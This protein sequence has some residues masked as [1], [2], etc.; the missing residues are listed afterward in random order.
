MIKTFKLFFSVILV[1]SIVV[2][3]SN[4]PGS[5]EIIWE[6]YLIETDLFGL[7]LVTFVII[8]SILIFTFLFSSIKN[9]PKDLQSNRNKRNLN[10]ANQSLDNIAEAF[11]LGDSNSIER[12]SRKLKKFLNNDFFS[13]FML[14][15]TSLIKND[16]TKSKEYLR[17]LESIPRAKYISRRA[18]VILL[19]K[20]K[21]TLEVKSELLKICK[22]Y[23]QDLWFHDKLS[24][25]YALEENWKLAHDSINNLKSIPSELKNNLADLK[26]L[27]GASPLDAFKLSSNS[28]Q[29]VKE[30]LR[31]YIDRDNLKKAVS[32]LERTWMNLLCLEIIEVFMK[33]KCNNE[34][35]KLK[36]Y[37]LVSKILKKYLDEESNETKLGLAF[38]SYEASIWGESQN[39]LNKIKS[40][41]WDERALDLYKKV[42]TK[43]TKEEEYI[44]KSKV[45]L[46][47]KWK[48]VSCEAQEENWQLF[49][50]NCSAIGSLV[51]PK[52]KVKPDEESNY[53]KDFLQNPLGHF[54]KMKREN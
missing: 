27:S 17:I 42:S 25:I 50:K 4:N 37:K 9:I 38:A 10:L 5:V 47:P 48:C 35:E 2:W 1:S 34:K 7:T 30:T 39:F 3:L 53:F 43:T 29:V 19:M 24:R 45:L 22:E 51:W 41:E 33:Y 18:K 8:V 46:K 49:C 20:D 44:F 52:S 14:F 12:N 16:L 31:F 13:V 15:N 54:P 28:I 40:E 32:I 6:N 21:K 36:R 11:L 26:I 23:P